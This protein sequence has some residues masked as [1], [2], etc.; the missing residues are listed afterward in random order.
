MALNIIFNKQ[1]AVPYYHQ[2]KEAVKALITGGELKPDDMLTSEFGL[3]EQLVISLPS[4]RAAGCINPF[5]DC[6]P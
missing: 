6:C 3:S 2:I 5:L 1:S 4:A